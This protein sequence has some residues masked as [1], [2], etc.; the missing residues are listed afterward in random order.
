L[1]SQ[2]RILLLTFGSP[3]DVQPFLAIGQALRTLGHLPVIATSELYREHVSQ[4]GLAFAPVRPD[5]NVCQQD[6]D[7]L[8][9]VLRDGAS[10]ADVFRH[11]FLPSLRESL[12]DVLP[13]AATADA[14]VTHP[15]A[16]S[17]RLA[18]EALGRTWV[19]AVLQPLGYL[20]AHEPPV[21]GPPWIAMLLRA[22]GPGPTRRIHQAARSLTGY[23]M[24]EWHTIR[25][26]LELPVVRDH[27]LW[28]GQHSR[29]R[30]LGLFPRLLGAPQPDWPS[31]A[32]VAGF[33]FY[34]GPD[35][36]LDLALRRFLEDGERPVVFTLGTT[37]VN[38]PGYFYE[39]SAAAAT[40]LGLRAILVVGPGNHERF[41]T[42]SPDVLAVP[43]APHDLLFPHTQ[44][45]VHQGGIGTLSEA[46]LARK[47]MLIMPYGHDQADNAW[48]ATRLGVARIVPRQRYREKFV[49]RALQDLLRDAARSTTTERVGHAVAR[50]QGDVEA[51]RL[52]AAALG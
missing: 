22:L 52:I 11:M 50:E 42:W 20:S 35:R 33:P 13:I 18:A 41:K 37:A 29:L 2:R 44:A 48:R 26:E 31:Q 40:R 21:V 25:A 7:F 46:L 36:A 6:P 45:I 38:D 28:E 19:S 14:I 27:P 9:R 43:Y 8:D 12:A 1:T 23:W 47:P 39:E 24:R 51:A 10:P 3:G 17:G 32:R 5:R 49:R 4:A 16:T 15:L 30:S 34:R